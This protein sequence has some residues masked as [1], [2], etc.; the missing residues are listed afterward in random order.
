[1]GDPILIKHLCHLR[2]DHIAI[3]GHRN[4]GYFPAGLGCRFRSRRLF[5]WLLWI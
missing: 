1:M 5:A 4:K 3:V 2:R